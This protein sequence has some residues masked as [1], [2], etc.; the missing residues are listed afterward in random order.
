M[1][2][3]STLI[4]LRITEIHKSIYVNMHSKYSLLLSLLEKSIPDK[5][6]RVQ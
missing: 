1:L 2:T 3:H 4:E 6:M 5:H